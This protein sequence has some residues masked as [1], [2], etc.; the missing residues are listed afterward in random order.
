MVEA[1]MRGEAGC[2]CEWRGEDFESLFSILGHFMDLM[3]DF[4]F[5]M[6][7]QNGVCIWYLTKFS[8]KRPL[9][10]KSW[11]ESHAPHPAICTSL[12]QRARNGKA[13]ICLLVNC[14]KQRFFSLAF[15][16][17][18][19]PLLRVYSHGTNMK[20]IRQAN[21]SYPHQLFGGSVSHLMAQTHEFSA[22]T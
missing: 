17:S 21:H 2:V 10:I 3:A 9:T 11:N 22:H 8:A 1:E 15:I 18:K 13:A 20:L 16:S 7:K 5:G 4:S 12:D 6:G 19:C 14:A